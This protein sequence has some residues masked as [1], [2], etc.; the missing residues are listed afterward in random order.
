MILLNNMNRLLKS[1]MVVAL[2]AMIGFMSGCDDDDDPGTPVD[3]TEV[4][5]VFS[6]LSASPW[7]VSAVTVDDLDFSSTYSGLNLSF[8]EGTYTSSNGGGI[9]SSAGTWVFASSAAEQLI[10]DG[11]LE[12][13]VL[14]ISETSLVIGLVSTETSLGTGGRSESVSGTHVFTFT[15]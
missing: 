14:E 12:V 13:D 2:V 1:M 15:K 5:R 8:A 9:F 3:E 10:L 4:A 6:L 7:N 11:D